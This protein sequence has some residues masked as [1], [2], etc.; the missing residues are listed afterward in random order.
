MRFM[1]DTGSSQVW[2]YEEKE[3]SD[4]LIGCPNRPKFQSSESSTF[5]ITRIEDE[6]QYALGYVHGYL[7]Q[8]HFCYDNSGDEGTCIKDDKLRWLVVDHAEHMD[9]YSAS[10]F[11][12]LAPKSNKEQ[13]PGLLQQI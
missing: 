1:F 11:V 3:C 8:D 9:T 2:M 12:G 13:F 6:I 7:G 10:G 4:S 5:T